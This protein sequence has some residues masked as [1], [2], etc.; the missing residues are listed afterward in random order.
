MAS[1]VLSNLS[2]LGPFLTG[3][4]SC[5]HAKR[6]EALAQGE[7][8]V[9]IEAYARAHSWQISY[10]S[11]IDTAISEIAIA[12]RVQAYTKAADVFK[13][14]NV[15]VL[16]ETGKEDPWIQGAEKYFRGF[17]AAYHKLI[18]RQSQGEA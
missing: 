12:R 7:L 2:G 11:A 18:S 6:I 1:A 13:Q 4:E 10:I 5:I 16:A 3:G 14:R 17:V 8:L 15:E 9:E